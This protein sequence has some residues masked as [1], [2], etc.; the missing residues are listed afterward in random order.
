MLC[1]V[2]FGAALGLEVVTENAYHGLANEARAMA[3]GIA[4]TNGAEL[5]QLCASEPPELRQTLVRRFSAV[6][7]RAPHW[8]QID[9]IGPGDGKPTRILTTR[10]FDVP[11]DLGAGA[12][13][14]AEHGFVLRESASGT[15][16]GVRVPI[17]GERGE[18][19]GWLAVELAT[20]EVRE[21]ARQLAVGGSA[22][23]LGA[24][25]L[26]GFLAL[27]LGRRAAAPIERLAEY[28]AMVEAGRAVPD[29]LPPLGRRDELEA[30]AARLRAMAGTLAR[31]DAEHRRVTAGLVQLDRLREDVLSAVSEQLR[32][33]VSSILAYCD[34]LEQRG[35]T[36]DDEQ[37]EFLQVVEQEARRLQAVVDQV[38]DLSHYDL[39]GIP[40][41]VTTVDLHD[42]VMAA[43]DAE[44]T[45]A[46]AR[47]TC[48]EIAAH[49][50]PQVA[51]DRDRTIRALRSLLANAIRHASIGG[52]VRLGYEPPLG[53]RGG[54]IVIAD[55]GEG[56]EPGDRDRVF[57]L[58][59]QGRGTHTDEA[60]GLGVGLPLARVC[61]RSQGGD[62]L[63][64]WT[65]PQ[66]SG[67]RLMLPVEA[68]APDAVA[69][70]ATAPAASPSGEPAPSAR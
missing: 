36:L 38:V 62:V 63:L 16:L 14:R 21:F 66:G 48:I 65:G 18:P 19:C 15:W 53:G 7:A 8:A 2:L 13:R 35:A 64:D 1:I 3:T 55:D 27:V 28:A 44:A 12:T 20:D 39:E 59:Y 45:G 10:D 68:T 9:V 69:D 23:L 46:A 54:A 47:R 33:P 6:A 17:D 29:A 41:E 22:L 4:S 32:S 56:I 34:L 57:D 31:R 37:R 49:G 70:R 43:V 60:P 50:W 26:A 58:F 51:I 52:N 40:L 67:F 61:M 42:V 24:A 5:R 25:L 30:I 11:A